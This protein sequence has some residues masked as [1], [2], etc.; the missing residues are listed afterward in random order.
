MP[1]PTPRSAPL[2]NMR[3][4]SDSS[5]SASSSN[6]S[7]GSKPES[8]PSAPISRSPGPGSRRFAKRWST[9][10][11]A[12]SA[13]RALTA[14]PSRLLEPLQP[15][16]PVRAPANSALDPRRRSGRQGTDGQSAWSPQR[17]GF[18]PRESATE[19]RPDFQRISNFLTVNDGHLCGTS[20]N[21]KRTESHEQAN[22]GKP[23]HK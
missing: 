10:T 11:T 7:S 4:S 12:W 1:L 22:S 17:R 15:L 3:K 8:R 2:R 18:N 21:P 13:A 9:E 16:S 6:S 14:D 19:N 23:C 20:R 5:A